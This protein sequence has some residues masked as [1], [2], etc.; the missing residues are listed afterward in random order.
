MRAILKNDQILK[1]TASEKD[2]VEIGDTP[3][4]IGLERLRFDGDKVIDL[5]DL[6][7][8]WVDRYF[9]LHCMDIDNCQLVQMTYR[10]RK[11]LV[12]YNGNIRVK[13]P[14]E[15][16][17]EEDIDIETRKQ[18]KIKQRIIREFGS[19]IQYEIKRDKCFWAMV[20]YLLNNNTDNIQFVRN[21]LDKVKNILEIN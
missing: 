18:A 11:D 19:L 8:I 21:N 15:V 3:N 6:N 14:E 17:L 4:G 2:G 16:E 1:L 20:D 13:T 12:N 5:A 10:E 9:T 7:Q